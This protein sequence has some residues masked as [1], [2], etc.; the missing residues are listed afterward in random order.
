M[1][2]K[3][4]IIKTLFK[5]EKTKRI[6]Q[7]KLIVGQNLSREQEMMQEMFGNDRSWG[8]GQNLPQLNNTLT[9]GYGL[10]NNDDYGETASM[11][12]VWRR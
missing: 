11:F 8:T 7:P 1:E 3:D 9:S 6:N 10:I 2:K 4:S 12:G 5:K